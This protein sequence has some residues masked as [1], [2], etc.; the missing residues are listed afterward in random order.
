M[1]ALDINEFLVRGQQYTMSFSAS[2]LNYITAGAFDL[3]ALDAALQ[4]MSGLSG[5][6]V[7]S[8]GWFSAQVNVVFTYDGDGTDMVAQIVQDILTAFTNATVGSWTYVGTLSSSL[9]TG[10]AVAGVGKQ[11]AGEIGAAVSG[12]LP[13]LSSGLWAVVVIALIAV[14]IFSG[15][16][17]VTK[18]LVSKVK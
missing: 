9:K 2:A 4:G 15:G 17:G 11:T 8:S 13:N 6:Q 18:T 7:I 12:V 14:F 10:D 1:P 16:I 5:T 3:S